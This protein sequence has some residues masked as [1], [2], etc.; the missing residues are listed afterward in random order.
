MRVLARCWCIPIRMMALRSRVCVGE[1]GEAIVVLHVVLSSC[2][3]IRRL[4]DGWLE[5][6][7]LGSCK[8][9]ASVV[10][11]RKRALFQ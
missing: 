10:G 8:R 6:V 9:Q 7:D 1:G 2:G 5:V 3:R 11:W 4:H